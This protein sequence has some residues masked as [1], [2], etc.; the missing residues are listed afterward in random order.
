MSANLTVAMVADAPLDQREGFYWGPTLKG[1]G[2]RLRRT[3]TARKLKARAASLPL[4]ALQLVSKAY[5]SGSM[6][7]RRLKGRPQFDSI[8]KEAVHDCR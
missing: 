7:W 2:L 6:A 8:L 1:F 4:A 3:A 5:V